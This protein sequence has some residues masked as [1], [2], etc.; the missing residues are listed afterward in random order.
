MIDREKVIKGLECCKVECVACPEGCPYEN[1]D[2]FCGRCF[3][4][5][6]TD[7]Y[8][9]IREQQEQ[10]KAQQPGLIPLD[11]LLSSPQAQ[12]EL[13]W[14]ERKSGNI[15]PHRCYSYGKTSPYVHFQ[16]FGECD[17]VLPINEYGKSWRCWE[18]RPSQGEMAK[19]AW[20]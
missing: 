4:V 18:Y 6:A 17:Y 19:M 20:E 8:A 9:L 5:L 7:A 14:L 3:Q 10:L 11:E 16:C 15:S 2:G 12:F 1:E 13:I